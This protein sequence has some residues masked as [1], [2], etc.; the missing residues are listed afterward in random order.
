[1]TPLYIESAILLNS[2]K[3]QHLQESLSESNIAASTHQ[4]YMKL[5]KPALKTLES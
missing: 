1:M 4:S 2:T 5:A 3:W